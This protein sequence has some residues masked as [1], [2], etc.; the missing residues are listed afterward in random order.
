MPVTI[1]YVDHGL[2]DLK[3]KIAE[4]R[5]LSLTVGIQ[6]DAK[7]PDGT[8]VAEVALFQEYGT[9]TIPARPF[10]RRPLY[11]NRGAI[12][13]RMA[14]EIGLAVRGKKEIVDALAAVGEFA[15][16][17][18][19]SWIRRG[20][21]KA[22]APSTIAKKGHAQ[23]LIDSTLLLRSVSW[24]VRRDGQIIREGFPT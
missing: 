20:T 2:E 19:T 10:L 3:G 24:A 5:G 23:P 11:A 22:L 6:N 15:A 12:A 1:K 8:S 18:V 21:F 16:G 7:Y 17:K 13:K 9:E 4:L 14:K